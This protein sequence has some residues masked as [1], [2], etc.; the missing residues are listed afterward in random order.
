LQPWIE[1]A[2]KVPGKWG[3]PARF[4]PVQSSWDAFEIAMSRI[5]TECLESEGAHAM[6]A[7]TG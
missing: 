1:G 2:P 4:F 3:D 5:L 7:T 6:S